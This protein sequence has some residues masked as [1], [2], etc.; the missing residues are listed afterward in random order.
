MALSHKQ[1]SY[2]GDGTASFA[3][4]GI[5]F[6]PK[7]V[8]VSA[9]VKVGGDSNSVM[10][11]DTMA[12]G[13]SS[14][15]SNSATFYTDGILSLDADG[16]TVGANIRANNTGTVYYYL[17][18]GGTDIFTGAYTGNGSGSRVITGVGFEPQFVAVAGKANSPKMS[19]FISS[20]AAVNIAQYFSNDI[21]IAN[22]IKS[23]TSDGFGV[24]GPGSLTNTNTTS[25][26][27]FCIKASSDV[28]VG[29]YTGDGTDN[30]DITGVG[31][32]PDSV[33]IKSADYGAGVWKPASLAG[34]SAMTWMASAASNLIQSF[35]S[36][37]FQVG[38]GQAVNAN[39]YAIYY[40]ALKEPIPPTSIKTFNSLAKA[41]VKTIDSLAIASV[42]SV[43]N[44]E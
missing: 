25:Y 1:G 35:S 38:S 16:F 7:V 9:G 28:A 3:I 34:D 32:Q 31:F 24:G 8:M 41:S 15:I 4:T 18:L 23:I 26:Y 11:F 13:D 10:R 40:L 39:T 21:N 6:T 42:K 27:H 29:T 5:G 14:P 22:Q 19:K 12:A 2:T 33:I 44:L 37:G 43:N 20:G 17:A 36:D 30:R